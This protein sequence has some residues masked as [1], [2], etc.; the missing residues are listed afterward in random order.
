MPRRRLSRLALEAAYLAGLAAAL[1]F[2]D[3]RPAAVGAFMLAGWLVVALF[4]WGALRRQPHYGSGLPPRWYVPHVRLPPPRPLEQLGS[5]YPAPD[6][7][8]DEATWIAPAG[9]HADWPVL[10]DEPEARPLE[11]QEEEQAERAEVAAPAAPREPEEAEA[12]AEEA[13]P[14]GEPQP[15]PAPR[16]D[17]RVAR[18]RVDPLAEPAA[19]GRRL[20]RRAEEAGVVEVPA[21]PL[22]PRP[23]PAAE[24]G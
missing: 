19:R 23:L 18:H 21:Q 20:R 11:E 13:E 22:R 3:L 15:P 24:D 14:A 9:L 1:A 10:D 8:G 5:G 7:A 2:A 16:A 12:G 6:A 17:G 4:E